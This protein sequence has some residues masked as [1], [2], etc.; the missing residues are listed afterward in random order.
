MPQTPKEK[1]RVVV[2]DDTPTV[3]NFLVSILTEAGMNVLATGSDGCDAVRLLKEL[4]PDVITLDIR[5]PNMDGFEAT[6]RIMREQPTPIVIVTGSMKYHDVELTFQALQAGAL[7][8]LN[9]PGL[10]DPQTCAKV[11]QTVQAMSGVRVVHHW[12]TRQ[13]APPKVKIANPGGGIS[14]LMDVSRY[15]D[16]KVIGIASST[17]GPSAL[18]AVLGDLPADYPLPIL[19]V[20]HVSPGFT[21]GLVEWLGSVTKMQ[22]DVATYGDRLKPGT[23]FFAPDDYHLQVTRGGEIELSHDPAYK[24]LRPSANPLFE[25]LAQH[26]GKKSMGIILT[27][28]GDDGANGMELLHQAGGLTIAQDKE[29]CVVYGMPNEAM[30]RN[31][32]DAQMGLGEIASFLKYLGEAKMN[33]SKLESGA[34]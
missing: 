10:A 3:R 24:G 6:R 11:V 16:I 9:K 17:G 4:K 30:I 12:G 29:S 33:I 18:S 34:L 15:Q 26:Y 7:A 22:V 21:T 8:V 2:V 1:I 20:Q 23:I 32:V 25:S 28:M 31:A 14:R 27:G 13:I 5:M 19:V